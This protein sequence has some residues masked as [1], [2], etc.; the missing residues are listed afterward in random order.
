M[1]EIIVLT[2]LAHF[3][4]FYAENKKIILGT[5][6][7]KN[8]RVVL[9]RADKNHTFWDTQ[10]ASYSHLS[11][12]SQ[13]FLT[14]LVC[15]L[16]DEG[17]ALF[18]EGEW[19]QAVREFTEG[20]NV[21]SYATAEDLPIPEVLLESLYVNR[22]AAHHSMVRCIWSCVFLRQRVFRQLCSG[23]RDS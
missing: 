10:A 19:E 9:H 21:L 20:L 11:S 15:N 3:Y 22:A 2:V 5:H 17:N 18:R 7:K 13:D 23:W 12:S 1:L 6:K 16:L 8:D 4:C 14:Q